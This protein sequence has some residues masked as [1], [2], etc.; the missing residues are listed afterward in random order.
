MHEIDTKVQSLIVKTGSLIKKQIV[1]N[2]L[3][4]VSNKIYHRSRVVIYVNSHHE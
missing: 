4:S 2:F 3:L 1:F